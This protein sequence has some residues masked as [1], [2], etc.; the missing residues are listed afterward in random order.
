[1][2]TVDDFIDQ[3]LARLNRVGQLTSEQQV[4]LFTAGLQEPLSIDIDLQAPQTMET[5]M[6]L[7]RAYEKTIVVAAQMGVAVPTQKPAAK[8][9][10]ARRTSTPIPVAI[11][12]TMGGNPSRGGPKRVFRRI[13][14]L[15]QMTEQKRLGLRYN[16]DEKFTPTHECKELLHIELFNEMAGDDTEDLDEEPNLE[17]SLHALTGLNTGH[18]MQLEVTVGDTILMALVDSGST[19]NFVAEEIHDHL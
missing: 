1:M 15:E 3:F 9:S 12:S 18:T 8:S 4:Q 5:T 7:A 17:I 14:T 11:K 6:S 13:L 19:H 16:C 2:G 10:F